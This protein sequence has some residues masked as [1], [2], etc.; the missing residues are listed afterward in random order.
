LA[1]KAKKPAAVDK[2]LSFFGPYQF[3]TSFAMDFPWE[4]SNQ[5]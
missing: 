5:L 3:G 2:W 1:A 4:I